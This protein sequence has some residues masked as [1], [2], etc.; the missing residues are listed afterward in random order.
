MKTND[1]TYKTNYMHNSPHTSNNPHTT[2]DEDN[3]DSISQRDTE[4]SNI[5]DNFSLSE[6]FGQPIIEKAII[7]LILIILLSGLI[8]YYNLKIK[9]AYFIKILSIASIIDSLLLLFY[10]FLRIKINSS[11]WFDSF[12]IHLYNYIDY[13]IIINFI[14]KFV[15]FIM[16]FFSQKTL[17]SLVLFCMKFLIE[18]YFLISCVKLLIFIP[19][20]KTLEEYFEKAIEGIKFLLICCEND[21]EQEVYDYKR[22]NEDTTN[23]DINGNEL[24]FV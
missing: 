15:L 18:L 7:L 5:L 11:Q 1:T 12:P 13:I 17:G 4:N 16:S 19:G 2:I 6:K 23:Y 8:L 21:H 14:L 9:K 3:S 10:C 24:Q 20:F 22:I